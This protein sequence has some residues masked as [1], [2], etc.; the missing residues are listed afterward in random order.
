MLF[1][2]HL[3]NKALALRGRSLTKSRPR[4]S[5]P[6]KKHRSRKNKNKLFFKTI[7]NFYK[8]SSKKKT[9]VN[10]RRASLNFI[11]KLSLSFSIKFKRTF[12]KTLALKNKIRDYTSRLRAHKDL[13]KANLLVKKLSTPYKSNLQ[14]TKFFTLQVF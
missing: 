1:K 12:L 11:E 14:K 10:F 3:Y 5:N 6:K 4:S 13:K 2:K 9:H 8:R 7:K